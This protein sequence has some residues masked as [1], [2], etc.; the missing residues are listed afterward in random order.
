MPIAHLCFSQ[1]ARCSA[2][3]RAQREAAAIEM[4]GLLV[5][6][7]ADVNESVAAEQTSPE[8]LSLLYGA[9][10]HA[11]NEGLARWLLEQGADPNDNE[12]LYHATEQEDGRLVRLLLQ[13]GA[14]V[15]GTNALHRAVNVGNVDALS[16]LLAAG[17]DPNAVVA[18]HPSGEPLNALTP[19]HTAAIVDAPRAV[20][21]ALLAAGAD[22]ERRWLGR[23]AYATARIH[24]VTATAAAL[25][26]RGYASELTGFDRLLAD[27]AAGVAPKRA[28]A[29]EDLS[30]EHGGL[31]IRVAG[32]PGRAGHLRALLA[33]GFPER[34]VDANGMTALHIA[35]W[36]GIPENVQALLEREPDFDHVNAYG[37]DAVR[38]LLHGAEF[39]PKAH[40]RDHVAC[41][42]RLIAAGAPIPSARSLAE[43]RHAGLVAY[44][45]AQLS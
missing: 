16:A 6:H 43:C 21:D 23:S 9:I 31:L 34:A 38:T 41:A 26:E 5:A 8:P 40:A 42:Q 1:F 4:A 22:P 39:A 15:E 20:A 36:E 2:A 7:G 18:W 19:L 13:F 33:A 29:P 30:E 44:Y 14:R 37:G 32:L 10:A 3:E 11:G 12:S 25:E 45:E 24:G 28:L 35:L 17:A 27:C